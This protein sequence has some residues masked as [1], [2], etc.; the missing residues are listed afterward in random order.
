[1][2]TWFAAA[3]LDATFDPTGP[4]GRGLFVARRRD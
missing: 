2:A 4:S 3:G 1:M